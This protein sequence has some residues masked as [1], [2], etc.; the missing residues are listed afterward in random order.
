MQTLDDLVCLQIAPIRITSDSNA[1]RTV[2]A[3]IVKHPATGTTTPETNAVHFYRWNRSI[4]QLEL[5]TD[6]MALNPDHMRLDRITVLTFYDRD[7][8]IVE[9]TD[10]SSALSTKLTYLTHFRQQFRI[11]YESYHNVSQTLCEIQL[12]ERSCI[13][14]FAAAVDNVIRIECALLSEAG[15]MRM[16]TVYRL[17]AAPVSL[18]QAL[19]RSDAAELLVLDVLG[20]V[21]VWR[22]SGGI[23][24]ADVRF[25]LVQTLQTQ[26]GS[27]SISVTRYRGALWLAACAGK[28]VNSTHF[29]SVEVYR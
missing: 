12:P 28:E 14:Y 27:T 29:G 2:F 23:H 15:D 19:W 26:H 22:Q 24:G 4:S 8:L 16:Q 6:L 9:C 18:L 25:E 1:H 21:Y 17:V 13:G 10:S 5:D 11:V 20:R 3:T 7:Y